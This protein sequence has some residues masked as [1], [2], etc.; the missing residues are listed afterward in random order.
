MNPNQVS[1]WVATLPGVGVGAIFV[2][3]SFFLLKFQMGR[4]ERLEERYVQ[5]EEQLV[6]LTKQTITAI[7]NNTRAVDALTL[8]IDRR[9]GWTPNPG[10][11][12]DETGGQE[13]EGP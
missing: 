10:P 13:S 9:W 8:Q 1:G 5:K 7:N 4:F 11:K 2:V 6:T 3:L 12:A